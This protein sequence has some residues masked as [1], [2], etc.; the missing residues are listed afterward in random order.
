MRPAFIFSALCA[1]VATAMDDETFYALEL[2]E[3][4]P[5]GDKVVDLRFSSPLEK[6]G[7][8]GN[9]PGIANGE[10]VNYFSNPSVSAPLKVMM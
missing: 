10:C 1:A 5:S 6:R 9:I 2:P 8:C 4:T 3:Y 7:G